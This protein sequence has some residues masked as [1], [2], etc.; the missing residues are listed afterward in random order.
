MA[1]L[2]FNSLSLP[3][4]QPL[5]CSDS[6]SLNR[7]LKPIVVNGNP[8]TF[9]SAPGRRI[10]AVGDL[11]G[12]L[13]QAKRAL[14]MA[15][16]LSSDGQDSWAGGE[17]VNGNHETMN[18]EGDFRYVDSGAFDECID[19][20]EYL[21]DCDDDWDEAF[22]RWVSVSERWKENRKASE[23]HWSPWN[24]MKDRGKRG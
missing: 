1:S 4:S 20:L 15:G 23:N 8:P 6:S 5:K 10:V 14:E 16:V 3:P 19:F 11:H 17:A 13:A 9:V 22:A 24:L 2:A 18:I 12:D 7:N 21:N